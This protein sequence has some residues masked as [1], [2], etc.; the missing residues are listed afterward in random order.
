MITVESPLAE[1][2]RDRYVLERE[3]GRGG[4][5]TVYLARDL[6]HHRLVA[7]KI[8]HPELAA[9]LGP[10]RFLQEIRTTARLDHPHILPVFDSGESVG[11]LWYTMP[12]VSG[13]SL[14]D[15]LRR[16]VQLSIDE[17]VR[18]TREVADAL[19]YAHQQGVIHRDIKPENILLGGGHARVADFGV[20][21]ALEAAGDRLTG[22]GLA[23]GTPVYMS[24]EQAS[25]AAVDARSD[26]YALACVLYEMLAGEPPFTGPN[27]QAVIAKR[28]VGPVPS[29][30]TTRPDAPEALELFLSKA[31]AQ[32]PA[33]R[34]ASLGEFARVL[35]V[36]QRAAPAPARR[37]LHGGPRPALFMALTIVVVTLAL[38]V[39]LVLRSQGGAGSGAASGRM[40]IAVL[41]FE[42]LGR[43]EDEYFAD[44]MTDEVRGKLSAVPGLKVIGRSSSTEYKRTRKRPS[45]IVKELDVQYLLTATVR[46]EKGTNGD[47]V[48]VSPELIEAGDASAKW[49]HS[50]DAPMTDVFAVQGE[51]AGH[52]AQALDVV[53]GE[54][55]AQ[56]LG[57]GPTKSLAAYDAYLKG[58]A[59]SGSLTRDEDMDQ[60]VRYFEEAVAIDS[61]FVQAWLQL[62]RARAI[63]Y[64]HGM[65]PTLPQKA[66]VR[67]AAERV[68]ELSPNGYEAHWARA[69]YYGV[70][71]DPVRAAAEISQARR[72]AP[73][74]SDLLRIAAEYEA[75]AG[76]V[77]SAI[78]HLRMTA[79][80][81]P[82]SSSVASGLAVLLLYAKP[83][84]EAT[85]AADR[86]LALDPT[87]LRTIWQAASARIAQGDPVAARRIF[88][89]APVNRAHL[90]AFF[91]IIEMP[92]L[93]DSSEQRAVLRMSPG[94]FGNDRTTWGIALAMIYRLHGDSVRARAYADSARIEQQRLVEA[95]PE[96]ADQRQ[97]LATQLAVM[98]RKAEAMREGERALA[99]AQAG[100]D[101]PLIAYVQERLARIYLLLG[102]DEKA[103]DQ[104]EPLLT[105]PSYLSAGA[106]RVDPSFAS[107]RGSPR[108]E[109]LLASRR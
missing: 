50:F 15:R 29:V 63:I 18:I 27:P 28:F 75:R 32:V 78:A 89:E 48:R 38:G 11:Q 58:E 16:D 13:E 3:L 101:V 40:R 69:E 81:D 5:A 49:Q 60:A 91:A 8:L 86:A 39:M 88:D 21:R 12:F 105:R 19:E 52:V 35:E 100:K 1:A 68:V 67:Q 34:F 54:S 93:L 10:E 70:L 41:P 98:G 2:L 64:L 76:N 80:L 7:L 61:T 6:K 59:E 84:A 44:G 96:N 37:T 82:R 83:G 99:Q 87:S 79:V 102:E 92:W 22:T 97:A 42:N 108:F 36:S 4:M 51:I 23:V 85:A 94:E 25:G 14:R 65:I 53:L 74:H 26:E 62:T 24:P 56:E 30:R 47:R 73:T 57:T 90:T 72:L 66:T 103:L 106:L 31:L 109:R 107:L 46:W 17:A 104:L 9:T 71:R 77:D 45:E 95:D 55:E 20:A 43:P 33:A